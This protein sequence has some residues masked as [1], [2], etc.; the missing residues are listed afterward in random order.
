M[1]ITNNLSITTLDVIFPKKKGHTCNCPEGMNRKKEK[2]DNFPLFTL[3][4]K[5]TI[6]FFHCN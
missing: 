3:N 5:K 1:D 4:S 2:G 6:S